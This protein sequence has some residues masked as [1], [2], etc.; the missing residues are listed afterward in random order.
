MYYRSTGVAAAALLAV[1]AGAWASGAEAQSYDRLVVFGDSLSDNGNLFALSGG[2]QPPSPPYVNGRFSDGPVFAELLGFSL[3]GYGTTAGSVNYAFGGARTDGV[4]AFPFGTGQQIVDYQ[5]FGGVFGPNDLVSLWGGANNIFQGVAAAAVDPNPAGAIN[6]TALGAAADIT[7]QLGTIAGAGAGTILVSNLP[8][9]SATPAF[10]GSPAA[11]LVDL[12]VGTF[13][14][15]LLAGA[16]GVAASAPGTN[17]IYMDV[18]KATEAFVAAPSR[19]GVT[20]AT[21]PCFDGV[22][23]CANPEDYFYYDAVHPTSTGHELLASLA[24]DY[25]Y[26]ADF[27]AATAVQGETAL[28]HRTDAMETATAHLGTRGGWVAGTNI[29]VGGHIDSV[30][31]DARGPVA[32]AESE[33]YGLRLALETGPHENL[34]LGFGGGMTLSEV[35]VGQLSFET[36][37]FGLDAW[38]GW[39]SGATFLTASAGWSR[40]NYDDI[41]RMTALAPVVH[42]AHTQGDTVGARLQI[43]T[44]FDMGGVALSPRAAVTWASTEVDG[45]VEQGPAA[46]HRI[47]SRAIDAASG[48]IA[49]RAEMAMGD[50]SAVYLEGGY[51]DQFS[52]DADDV[53]VGLVDNSAQTLSRTVDDPFGSGA[54]LNAGLNMRLTDRLGLEAGYRG[55]FGDTDSHLG[56][57]TLRLG[58]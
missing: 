52:Y 49:L 48:E 23:V 10:N 3:T 25:L 57:I 36:E 39:R 24:T 58:F 55:R 11:P 50:R 54:L 45:Y 37:S 31:S 27:G 35:D 9:L 40:D 44:W 2:T 12:A 20:N 43:G 21:A 4:V 34:R 38:A 28:R 7:A 26:Y 42:L 15:A 41:E 32:E 14:R 18:A 47:G 17:I 53:R 30:T 5:G 33:G 8:R 51:R 16:Q 29:S 1:I 6:T 46:A 56:G 22:T 13:N 19:F